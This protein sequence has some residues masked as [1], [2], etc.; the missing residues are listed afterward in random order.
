EGRM[1]WA[2]NKRLHFEVAVI[3]AIQTLGQVTL[4]QV[5]AD[6]SALRDGK[7]P[8]APPATAKP[9][10]RP[11]VPPKATVAKV[12]EKLRVE[13]AKVETPAV[14]NGDG[15]IDF[16][17]LWQKAVEQIR[18]RRPLIKAWIDSAKMLGQ[19]G[20][21][22]VLGFPPEQKGAMESLGAPKMRDFLEAQLKEISGRDWSLK[23]TLKEGLVVEAPK[24]EPAAPP[25]KP[26]VDTFKND[27]LIREALEIF[28]GEIKP[29]TD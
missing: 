28:K 23:F 1:R 6:L 21:H 26:T 22:L 25:P 18:A 20:R 27:P 2:P 10:A 12:A 19:E 24:S 16:D 5:I 3:K 15:P 29:V 4:N 14:T 11:S 17:V 8:A 7:T 9:A 13:E